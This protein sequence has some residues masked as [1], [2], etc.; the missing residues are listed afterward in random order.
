MNEQMKNEWANEQTHKNNKDNIN[1]KLNN[2]DSNNNDDETD[3]TKTPTKLKSS[4]ET[5][6]R[7]DN[8]NPERIARKQGVNLNNEYMEVPCN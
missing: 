2:C 8:W 5:E 3:T 4:R 7:E 6:S 1:E